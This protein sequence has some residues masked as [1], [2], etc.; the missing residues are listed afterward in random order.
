[1]KVTE[2]SRDQLVELK[3]NY[4]CHVLKNGQDVAYSEIAGNV[5][6]VSDAEVFDYYAGVEFSED[7]F[8]MPSNRTKDILYCSGCGGTHVQ[9]MAWVDANTYKYKETI[10]MPVEVDDC[11]CEDC[12]EH[13]ELLTLEQLW[14]KFSE[15]LV[16]NNDEIEEDFLSFPV[17]TS[18][19]DVWHWFDERCPN[20]LHDDLLYSNKNSL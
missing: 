8:S 16:N 17:G 11:W 9:V 6:H 2:L 18:K 3:Q 12:E 7:D 5:S 13:V 1:M 10:N 14:E 19:F 15:V 4:L 20:N